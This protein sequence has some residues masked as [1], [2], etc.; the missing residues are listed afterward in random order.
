MARGRKPAPGGLADPAAGDP[1]DPGP[2]P[3][4]DLS[5]LALAKWRALV[6]LIAELCALRDT[7][8][9]ALRQYCDAAVR[10]DRALKALESD[11]LVIETPNGARQIN[12]LLTIAEKAEAFMFKLSERFGLDPASRKRLQIAAKRGASPLADFLKR[13]GSGAANGG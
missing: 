13:G 2:A 10:R 12:P 9:D 3:P 4:P 7:D 5:P 1:G 6:P 11:D 8:V